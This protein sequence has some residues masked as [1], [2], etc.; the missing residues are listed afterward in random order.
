MGIDE[1]IIVGE[2]HDIGKIGISE[3]ILIKEA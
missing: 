3:E 2:L 1:L